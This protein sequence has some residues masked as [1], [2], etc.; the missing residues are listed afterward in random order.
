MEQ[1]IKDIIAKNLPQHVGDVL[2]ERLN[3]ADK[4]EAE[5]DYLNRVLSEANKDISNFKEK[6]EKERQHTYSEQQLKAE[7]SKLE[8]RERNLEV[9][10][11]KLKLEES[12][13]RADVST[14]LVETV[15]RSPVYRK[16]VEYMTL[17]SY[18]VQGRYNQTSA[19]P[20]NV[21]E[22]TD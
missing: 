9:E 3:K 7:W 17:G 10:M 21:T 5:V 2:K 20:V 1:E 15:F 12:Q 8:E 14:K 18:D 13:K 19:V 22:V 11:L 16:H 6:L 4:L